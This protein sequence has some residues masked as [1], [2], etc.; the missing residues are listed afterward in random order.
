MNE[1]SLK[2]SRKRKDFPGCSVVKKKQSACNAG[3]TGQFLGWKDPLEENDKTTLAICTLSKYLKELAT[4]NP[5]L[6]KSRHDLVTNNNKK[7]KEAIPPW[8][9]LSVL[10]RTTSYTFH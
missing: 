2:Q 7:E 1:K 5:R 9:I 8:N 3:D 10:L 4:H 6:S